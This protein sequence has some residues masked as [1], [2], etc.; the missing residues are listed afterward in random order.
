MKWSLFVIAAACLCA[1]RQAGAADSP[2][3]AVAPPAPARLSR[4]D[5][6]R[7]AL[8]RNPAIEAAREQVEEAKAGIHVAT[9]WPDPSLVTE[10]DQLTSFLKQR[11]ATE[12]DIGLQFTVPY[13]NRTRLSGRVAKSAWEQARY[14]LEQLVQQTASQTAQA[15]DTLL[16]ALRHHE[17][18]EQSEDMSRQFLARTEARFRAGNVA[19]LDELKA[20]VDFS[21][22]K[23]DLIANEHAIAV[24]RATLN[25]L[26]GRAVAAPI[27]PA[28]ALELPGPLP[29]LTALKTLALHARPELLGMAAQQKGASDATALAR[30]YWIPDLNL[31]LW[32]SQIDGAPNSYKM[33][34][35]ISVPLLFWQHEKGAV[36]QAKHHERE[37]RATGA[38][39]ESQVLLDVE[40]TYSTAITAWEQA[41]YLHDELLPQAQAAYNAAF[42]SYS[43]GGS[44][45]I[46]L[47]DAKGTLLNAVSQYTDALGAVNTSRADLQRAVGAPLPPAP[48][49]SPHEK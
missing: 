20:R 39:L 22:T 29:D 21:K 19:K 25:R 4:S 35:G 34:A 9:A 33:D 37:L 44:S 31:T 43:I 26:M 15:Y 23:N 7:E 30:Q 5:A 49:A 13:P 46:E 48:S 27:E 17:D 2:P 32:R 28:D 12:R 16:V 10:A 24:A 40:T 11:S 8:A 42:T 1:P 14:A 6:I 3:G 41:V 38:D 18:L 36:A 45:S 47:L